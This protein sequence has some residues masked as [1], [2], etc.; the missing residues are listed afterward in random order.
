MKGRVVW[1]VGATGVVGAAL[2]PLLA[3]RG[4]VL[5]LTGRK[6]E[7]LAEIAKAVADAGGTAHT[8]ALDISDDRAIREIAERIAADCGGIDALVNTVA[9]RTFGDFMKL[10]D[11]D[12]QEVLD[13]KLMGYIRTMRASIPHMQRRGGGSIVNVSGRGGRQP[14]PAHLPGGCAN[15]AVN[16]L[17]KGVADVVRANGIR[18]NVVAPGPIESDRFKLIERSNVAAWGGDNKRAAMDHMAQPLDIANAIAFLLG[19]AARHITGTVLAVD[20]GGTAT[21]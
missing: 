21:V 12:W 11:S 10:T 19:D 15:A 4:A 13:T 14:T 9:A 7:Q 8:Y 2:A 17:S 18:I 20:G 6:Q 16:L 1:I 3:S 5:A